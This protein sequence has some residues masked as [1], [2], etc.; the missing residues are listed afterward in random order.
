M[1]FLKK[2]ASDAMDEVQEKIE[3]Q[4]NK[5]TTTNNSSSSSRDS[6]ASNSTTTRDAKQDELDAKAEKAI[7]AV[8]MM[9]SGCRDEQTSAD[10][11]DVSSFN[12]PQDAGPGGAGGAC[13]NS[14][15]ANLLNDG[16][17]LTDDCTWIELLRNMRKTLSSKRYTQIPQLS[18]SRNQNLDAKFELENP[19]EGELGGTKKALLVGINY[20]GQNGELNGCHND[21]YSM[22]SF[23]EKKG[24]ASDDCTLLLDTAGQ[25]QP[26]RD[27]ILKAIDEFVSNAKPGDSLF[28]HYSG[29]GASVK[30]DNGDEKDGKDETLVPLVGRK[31]FFFFFFFKY[32]NKKKN[33]DPQQND[34]QIRITVRKV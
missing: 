34:N 15:L 32:I 6:G 29:H 17:A 30:D 33:E 24:W 9:I 21:V 12:L 23:L 31:I 13:T 16:D 7:P 5:P 11:G 14:M 1:N 4:V 25:N 27:N 19:K 26:T 8:V 28:L 18:T 2:M 3:E 20:V 10:V 22:Q